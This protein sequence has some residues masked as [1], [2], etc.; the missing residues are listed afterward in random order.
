[1]LNCLREF[2]HCPAEAVAVG[3]NTV[4]TTYLGKDK[5]QGI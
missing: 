4:R 2:C 3:S 5:A 1:M